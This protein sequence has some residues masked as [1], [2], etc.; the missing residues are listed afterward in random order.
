MIKNKKI[1]IAFLGNIHF[2]S[3]CFNLFHSLSK[4]NYVKFLGFEWVNRKIESNENIIVKKINRKN[5]ILFY[6]NYYIRITA[7]LIKNKSDIYIAGDLYSLPAVVVAAVLYD[8][9]VIYDSRELFSKLAGLRNKP[10]QQKFWIIIEYMFIRFADIITVTGP[11]D[12]NFLVSKYGLNNVLLLRNLPLFQEKYHYQK[13]IES[14]Q[15]ITLVYQGVMLEGRGLEILLRILK[16][17]SG[18]NLYL[19]GDGELTPKL[20]MLVKEFELSERVNFIGSVH[21]NE[22]SNFTSQ[23]DVGIS[24]I[25]NISESYYYALPNK[26]FE[27]LMCGLPVI[28]S[29]LPQ[30]KDIVEKYN[31]GWIVKERDEDDLKRVLL[32]IKENKQQISFF[33]NNAILA[34]KELN[35][36]RE[37]HSFEMEIDF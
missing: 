23:G 26:M 4:E 1:I 9:K 35:W 16:D 12:K 11:M 24:F 37:F 28:V 18:I 20:K 5:S 14:E 10:L 22:L 6:L 3:R 27:Y 21:Q 2:D 13:V 25:E 30:M 19:I 29:N 17:V 32:T 33:S 8:A 36:E 15:D 31:V 34:A 7:S